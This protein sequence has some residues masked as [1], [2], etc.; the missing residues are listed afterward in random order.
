MSPGPSSWET[1]SGIC[2]IPKGERKWQLQI[3]LDYHPHSI[4]P[5][6]PRSNLSS[7]KSGRLPSDHF[8]SLLIVNLEEKLFCLSMHACSYSNS[9]YQGPFTSHAPSPIKPET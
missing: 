1:P 4:Y 9:I 3:G 6:L 2:R 7:S 8:S 5:L